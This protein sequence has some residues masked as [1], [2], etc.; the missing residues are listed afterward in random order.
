MNPGLEGTDP[1]D[2]TEEQSKKDEEDLGGEDQG[3]SLEQDKP[4]SLPST[5]ETIL[6]RGHLP[7]VE[8]DLVP[9]TPSKQFEVACLEDV[10]FNPKTKEIMWRIE[11]TQNMGDRPLVT[12]VA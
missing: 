8:L 2:C 3:Q 7:L 1:E 12:T 5:S 9:F 6:T 10:Y 4:E 11:K